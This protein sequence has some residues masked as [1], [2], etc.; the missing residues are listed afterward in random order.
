MGSELSKSRAADLKRVGLEGEVD[1]VR[2]PNRWGDAPGLNAAIRAIARAV[3]HDYG[4]PPPLGIREGFRGLVEPLPPVELTPWSTRG[5]ISRG[6]TILHTASEANPFHF[7]VGEGRY[8]DRSD[9]VMERVQGL[10]LEGLVVL[11]GEGSLQISARMAHKGLRVVAAPKTIDNDVWG[12]D[13]CFGHAT[14]RVT[15]ADA[16]DRLQITG[17]SHHRAMV[18]EVMG[19]HTGWI[20]LGAGIAGGAEA[21][22]IPEIPFDINKVCALVD[23]R[24][25]RGAAFSILVIAEGAAQY[26]EKAF[27][28]ASSDNFSSRLGGIGQWL[29]EQIQQRTGIASRVTVLGH[30]QRGGSPIAEDRILASQFGIAAVR[31]LA[32]GKGAHMV[33][34]R[35]D[36]IQTIPLA[37]VAGYHRFVPSDHL[38]LQTARSLGLML[39]E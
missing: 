31:A 10:G 28:G 19:R 26:G 27:R 36:Q 4:W 8:E 38:L 1:A 35:G 20:A 18:L 34:L 23:E 33:G 6:G 24:A 29:A 11:G 15:A 7:P 22:L 3:V 30:L 21:V 2:S 39:G 25:R 14:A 12:T 32:E 5:L 37:E 13:Q 17:E 9:R 16:L